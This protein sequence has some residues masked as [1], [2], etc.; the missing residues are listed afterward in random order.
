MS[1][2]V[3]IYFT[4]AGWTPTDNVSARAPELHPLR[5][6]T[7][8]HFGVGCLG[9]PSALEFARA[10]VGE[11]RILD[12]DHVDPATIVRWPFGLSAAGLPKV[13]VISEFIEK[14]YPATRVIAMRHRLGA[15][16]G[17]KGEGR[18]DLEVMEQM[19]AGASILFD[20]TAEI[21]VQHYLSDVAAKQGIPYVSVVGTYGGWGGE[22]VCI[23]PGRTEGCWMCY[24]HAI[25]DASIPVCPSDPNGKIQPRGCG[26]VTFTAAGFDM[27]QVALMAV[28]TA[29]AVL[30]RGAPGGYPAAPWDV[31]TLKFRDESGQLIVPETRGHHLPRHAQC[32]RCKEQ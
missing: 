12:D 10:G 26:D 18:S 8:A 9:G 27:T 19:T 29:V 11:L 6:R 25:E 24:R 2:A 14:N 28:R 23:T 32:P 20:A 13:Q 30:C 3:A 5:D 4:R 22:V 17:P 31:L 1:H 15:A 21:G 16:R 7:I